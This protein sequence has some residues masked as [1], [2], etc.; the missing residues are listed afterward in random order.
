MSFTLEI[1]SMANSEGVAIRV[2]KGPVDT[3]KGICVWR[4]ASASGHSS[5]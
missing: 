1:S 5:A 4:D 2:W 3:S